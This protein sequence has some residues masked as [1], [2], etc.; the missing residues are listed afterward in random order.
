MNYLFK[1]VPLILN[2]LAALT[3]KDGYK[4]KTVVLGALLMLLAG[5]QALVPELTALLGSYGPLVSAGLGLAVV[6][7]RTVTDAPLD[8][9]KA[10]DDKQG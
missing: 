2:V 7:L 5:L 1:L 3:T 4:S 9:N 10:P 8:S 6:A